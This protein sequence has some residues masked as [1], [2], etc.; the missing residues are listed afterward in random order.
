MTELTKDEKDEANI[1]WRTTA[2]PD[3]HKMVLEKK[4]R[5]KIKNR[6]TVVDEALLLWVN[7]K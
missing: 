4:R 7:K 5:L 2:H 3:V 6:A 1:I